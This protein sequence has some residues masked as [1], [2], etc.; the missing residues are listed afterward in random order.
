MNYY[1]HH[2]GDFNNAT[3]HLTRIERSIYRDLIEMYYDGEQ[4]LALDVAALCRKIVARTEEEKAA[5]L[6]VLDEFFHETPGGWFHDRC[7]EELDAFRKTRTQAAAA[8]KASAMARAERRRAAMTGNATT[9][10]R[11]G[12]ENPT[13]VERPLNDRCVSVQQNAN[14]APTNQEP[15]T[16]NQEPEDQTHV[17][18]AG[19]TS[20]QST[21]MMVFS[22]WQQIMDKPRAQLDVK[23]K[24]NI[25]ARLKDGYTVEQLCKAVDGCRA[26][27]FSMGRNDRS[28][29]YNDIE[30]ICRDGARV[31][32]FIAMEAR[33]DPSAGGMSAKMQLQM[34]ELN[35][36][37]AEG[38]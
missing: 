6:A 26:D 30:L 33:P 21:V 17:E 23:R 12:N 27:P 7:E 28:T 18:P 14:S 24:R 15:R 2:I 36:F 29:P 13:T 9:V 16:K 31:D 8:G 38:A 20:P 19:P 5:V 37:M 22:Y 11:D 34:E 1:S 4:A 25:T 10:E 35:R 32:R 3:R